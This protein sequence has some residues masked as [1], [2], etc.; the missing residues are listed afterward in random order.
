MP[1]QYFEENDIINKQFELEQIKFQE[2]DLFKT[3]SDNWY[4]KYKK[5]E[6]IYQGFKI[7]KSVGCTHDV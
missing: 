2:S 7:E 6:L 3:Q 5:T 4:K 1:L